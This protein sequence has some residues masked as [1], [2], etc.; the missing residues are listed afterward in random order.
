MAPSLFLYQP[1]NDKKTIIQIF[2]QK[3][4]AVWNGKPSQQF[5][6]TRKFSAFPYSSILKLKS[7]SRW[8]NPFIFNGS[9][10]ERIG[11]TEYIAIQDNFQ[12]TYIYIFT[13]V[14]FYH[15]NN[16]N[17]NIFAMIWYAFVRNSKIHVDRP[18]A[19]FKYHIWM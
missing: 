13:I 16:N 15:M 8:R 5:I 19:L 9:N 18:Y 14:V 4:S 2:L 17:S 12:A 11:D 7:C 1:A 10:L 6:F 3:R